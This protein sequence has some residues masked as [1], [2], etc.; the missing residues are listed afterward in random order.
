MRQVRNSFGAGVGVAAALLLS[1]CVGGG[2]GYSA[3]PAYPD[4]LPPAPVP[5]AGSPEA[6]AAL[7]RQGIYGSPATV[8][9][10]PGLPDYQR[11][12]YEAERR[13]AMARAE[14]ERR[15]QEEAQR[16]IARLPQAGIFAPSDGGYV[17]PP[18]GFS[19]P[20][21]PAGPAGAGQIRSTLPPLTSP[22]P[23]SAYPG[24]PEQRPAPGGQ[25]P[26]VQQGAPQQPSQPPAQ[27]AQP[28]P[29]A[30][31][32]GNCGAAAAAKVVGKPNSQ[33]VVL[34]AQQASGASEVRI[35]KPGEVNAATFKARRLNLVVGADRKITGAICG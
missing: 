26:P 34:E 35:V 33:S 11:E 22:S 1:A 5:E 8:Y 30:L 18:G 21:D 19:R 9:P 10:A 31:P 20:G 17:P 12:Q 23:S 25:R 24:G 3:Y 15:E 27:Q 16:R 29:G 13:A 4:R 14:A 6:R 7:A 32:A 2:G 28:G